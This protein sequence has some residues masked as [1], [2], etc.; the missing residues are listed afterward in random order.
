MRK[1]H[2]NG[3]LLCAVLLGIFA[4]RRSSRADWALSLLKAILVHPDRGTPSLAK[5]LASVPTQP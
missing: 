5:G 3:P 2:R 4:W 1:V